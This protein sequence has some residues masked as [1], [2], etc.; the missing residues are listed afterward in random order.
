MTLTSIPDNQSAILLRAACFAAAK[1]RDQRRKDV[2]ATP[3][4]NHPLEVAQ[5]LADH[6]VHDSDTLVAAL[7]HDTLEDTDT[8]PE[9]I[10]SGFGARVC[11]IVEEVSDNRLLPYRERKRKQIE[12]APHISHEGKLVKLADK[13]SNLR[14]INK[15]QP[16]GWSDDRCARYFHWA[17]EV[18][19]GLRGTHR[20]LEVLFDETYGCFFTRHPEMEEVR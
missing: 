11:H 2:R 12:R 17:R 3:Y 4:I 10:A 1:H 5:I 20:R 14:D 18:I 6:G 19:D 9:E 13:I 16:K 15:S 7:L 8:T